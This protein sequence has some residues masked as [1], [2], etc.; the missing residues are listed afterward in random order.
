MRVCTYRDCLLSLKNSVT[1]QSLLGSF[2]YTMIKISIVK[3]IWFD[4]TKR[5]HEV[6][7]VQNT[8]KWKGKSKEEW[9]HEWL[10]MVVLCLFH[11]HYTY[12]TCVSVCLCVSVLWL[13]VSHATL[14]QVKEF[15]CIRIRKGSVGLI[16]PKVSVMRFSISTRSFI[17]LPFLFIIVVV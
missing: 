7:E 11:Q 4:Y 8:N 5:G 13:C 2:S 14:M 10:T 12:N 6:L 1:L 15:V 3:V 9:V 16:L 17:R